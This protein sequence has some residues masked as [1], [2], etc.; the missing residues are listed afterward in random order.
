MAKVAVTNSYLSDIA[1]A[2][3]YKTSLQKTYKPSE[4]ANAINS[5]S[6]GG[7]I[8]PTGTINITENGSHDVTTY[9]TA[10]VQVSGGSTINNQNKSVTP[11]TS[12][13][14][15]NADAG[16]TGL[17]TVTVNAIPSEYII[18][19]GTLSITSNG[20]VNVTQ[21]ASASVAVP[22]GSTINN[23]DKT[24][25]ALITSVLTVNADSGY[26]GLGTVTIN[27]VGEGTIATPATSITANPSISLDTTNGLITASAIASKSVTPSLSTAGY[28]SSSYG[29]LTAGTISVSGSNSLQL[30]TVSANTITPTES[31][32]TAVASNVYTLGTIK[33]GAIS[34][35]YVGSGITRQSSTNMTVST[36][37]VTAPAGYY[38]TSASKSIPNGS[39]TTPATTITANPTISV[40]SSGLITAT[41]SKTQG[42]TP[43][44]SAGYVSSGTSGT[45]TVS[46]TN[47][48]QLTTKSATTYTPTTTNQTISSGTYLTGTQT[49]LGDENLVAGNI[50]KNVSIFN[51]TGSYEGSGGG[52]GLTV[53]TAT[54]TPSSASASISFAGLSG[55]PTSFVVVSASD[56]ATGASP[57]KTASVV[58][59]GTNIIGQEITNISNA[60]VTYVSSGWS[61]SYSSGTLTITGT[62]TNFQANQYK[63]I[64]TYG[65]SDIETKDV[66]VGSGVT[67]ITFT[68]LDDEPS[69]FSCIF[70]SDFSTSSGYTRTICVVYDGTNTYGMEMGSGAQATEHW[71]FTYNN[72]SLVIS[73]QST[74]AGGYFHQPGYYQLTYAVE[75][76][77]GNYQK[78]TVTPTDAGFTVTAD[79]GYDA[80]KQVVVEGDSDLRADNIKK[81]VSIFGVTGT[82]DPGGSTDKLVLLSTNALGTLST[83]STSATNTNVSITVKDVTDYDLLVVDASVDTPVSGNHTSTV[84]LIYL[85]GT[86]NVEQKGTVAVGSNKWNSKIAS[87]GVAST[88]QSTTAYGIYANSGTLSGTNVTIPF[89]YRYNANNSGTINGTYTARTYGVKLMDLIGG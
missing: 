61:K 64:Y 60:Q 41:A 54:A 26:T 47:T 63:L 3:R 78:K 77:S 13:Q 50:K 74:S 24:V 32:Q 21:Y 23:Q 85:T 81:N 44:V 66:Q 33:V 31:E 88:R 29:T 62:G 39:A 79:N 27:A 71:S 40:S 37:T 20:T 57:Y 49:I 87:N 22:G 14:T 38:S 8:T 56:L 11:T 16:Y 48:S 30:T 67:S 1:D 28:V 9:A 19:S 35:T 58:F 73:S 55:E 43:T 75:G 4:M 53:A 15:L 86:S 25:D 80:L 52:G 2:I 70:K 7:G 59:D 17:G 42:V 36:N 51:I 72:G 69:Y 89:Y 5:I 83:S 45:I 10:N 34:S 18:P 12:I 6:G 68:G 84:S 82:Y 65:G 76:S 46:G